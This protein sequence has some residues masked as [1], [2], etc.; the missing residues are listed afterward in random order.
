M[1]STPGP[2][3]TT[4]RRDFLRSLGLRG[5]AIYGACGKTET[6]VDEEVMKKR[7]LA[8]KEG[9]KLGEREERSRVVLVMG[10]W[11]GAV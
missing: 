3:L 7:L 10:G 5:V 11:L 4:D 1:G 9:Y 6:M 2:I 8:Y